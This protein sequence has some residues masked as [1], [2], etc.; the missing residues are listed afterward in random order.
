MEI[1][2]ATREVLAGFATR[3]LNVAANVASVLGLIVAILAAFGWENTA[4]PLV[5]V[6]ALSLYLLLRYVRQERWSR[7]AE[8]VQVM[9]RAHKRLKLAADGILFG[10]GNEE[11]MLE[12][13]Q[14]SLGAFAEAFTL[15]T[16]TNCR[17]SIKEVYVEEQLRTGGRSAV[18]SFE[19]ELFV[20]TI[21]RSD[22][23]ESVHVVS[24]TPDRVSENS[25]FKYVLSKILPFHEG[26]LPKKWL[27]RQYNNSHWGDDLRESQNF[28]YRSSI[29]WPIENHRTGASL[30]GVDDDDEPVI[31][32]LCVD[33]KRRHA[34]RPEADIQFGSVFS[35]ALYPVL[36][37]HHS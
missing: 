24:E 11:L 12:R 36:R 28:P 22:V 5:Y 20:A 29:V 32:V 23:D 31:A 1:R 3:P 14:Q 6:C 27:S 16:G 19:K 18:S 35:H 34:F 15:V 33:S 17:A 30:N 25:D 2:R 8:G 13:L 4:I 21:V 26:D 9:D 7:Y 37:Y 10:D